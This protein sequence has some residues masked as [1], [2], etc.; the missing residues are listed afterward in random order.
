MRYYCYL[1][2][3]IISVVSKEREYSNRIILTDCNM[4]IFSGGGLNW[5]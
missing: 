4:V 2:S 3:W 1:E 5:R